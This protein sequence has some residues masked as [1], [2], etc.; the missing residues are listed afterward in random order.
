MPTIAIDARKYFDFG[1]GIYIQNLIAS[2]PLFPTSHRFR[3]YVS[4]ADKQKVAVP[5]GWELCETRYG[6]Y[7]P[8]EFLFFG[9]QALKDG[10]DLFHA[11]HYTLPSGLR[12][13]SVVSIHDLI[14]L[15]FPQYFTPAQRAYARFMVGQAARYAGAVIT[16]SENTKADLID[17]FHIEENRVK[18]VHL[19][20]GQRFQPIEQELVQRFRREF[21]LSIPFL[22]SVGNVKPH[23]N[24]ST[25]LRAF[26]RVRSRYSDLQL[27]FVGGRCLQDR[28]LADLA[29]ELGVTNAIRDLGR[30][31]E[32]NVLAAYNA[33]EMLVFPSLYEGF[34]YPVVEAMA[35]GTPTVVSTGGSLREVAGDASLQC[36]P[37]NPDSFAEAIELILTDAERRASLVKLGIERAKRFSWQATTAQTL[38]VYDQVLEQCRAN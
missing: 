30:I 17:L 1:I 31:S 6:K 20:I 27:V 35:C 25:L 7:S 15:R 13:H 37:H 12:G 23:K 26:S 36:D 33:A 16:S 38:K 9:R 29:R 34:G 14:H 2:F 22:L 10:V 11:P 3:L 32:E 28:P 18:V 8:G 5:N 21:D 4:A 19:G 24:L